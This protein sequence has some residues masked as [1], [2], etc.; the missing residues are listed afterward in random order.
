MKEL[1]L[2]MS[3]LVV[4]I[5]FIGCA[6]VSMKK[7]D[8]LPVTGTTNFDVVGSWTDSIT[9]NVF[10]LNS[11]GTGEERVYKGSAVASIKSFEY[12]T[13]DTDFGLQYIGGSG[14]WVR[15]YSISPDKMQI[16][17]PEFVYDEDYDWVITTLSRRI[18]TKNRE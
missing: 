4:G 7:F 15:P 18:F 1:F 9:G 10:V 3:V 13:T 12:R 17:F 8:T 6:G 2:K 16:S 14:R 5:M 11:N